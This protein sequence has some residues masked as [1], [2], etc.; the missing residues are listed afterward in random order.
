MERR[1]FVTGFTAMLAVAGVASAQ[2]QHRV[3]RIGVIFP[4]ESSSE[5]AVAG[6]EA[7]LAGL[8][9]EGYVDGENITIEYRYATTV[10]GLQA[11][12]NEFVRAN[13]DVICAAG[14]PATLA[15]KRATKTIPIIG[16]NM[17]DPVADGLV[18]SLA[19]PGAN[20]TGNTFLA[21]EL[22][23]KRLQLFREVIPTINR[24]AVLQQ[25]GVYSDQTMRTMVTELDRAAKGSRVEVQ[26]FNARTPGDF[27][28]AFAEM[29]RARAGAL[30][31]FSSPMFYINYRQLI[32][33]SAR[34]RLPTMYYFPEAVEAGGLMCYGADL[35]DLA[36]RAGNYAAKILRGAKPSELPVEQPTKFDF[37]L[38]LKTAKALG[39]TIPPSL[40]QR[41]DKVIE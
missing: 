22:G 41:A 35:R 17:A 37:L 1:D 30:I 16:F 38:N 26:I 36:H 4:G 19:R 7:T 29:A 39:L 18:A 28:P 6:R 8:R 10:D 12:A 23:P 24:V 27:E 15:A 13:V 3:P 5:M 32:E 2:Q 9:D 21:P 34:H 20:I 25:P 40:L 11:A 31:L 33:L 14:T